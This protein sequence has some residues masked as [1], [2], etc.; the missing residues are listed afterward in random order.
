MMYLLICGRS[1]AKICK[2]STK[3]FKKLLLSRF[4]FYLGLASLK[5]SISKFYLLIRIRHDK[6][7]V[8]NQTGN[9]TMDHLFKKVLN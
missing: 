3:K 8:H 9:C 1:K 7:C 2:T 4:L 6:P 5:P